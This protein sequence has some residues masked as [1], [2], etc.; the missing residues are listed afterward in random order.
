MRTK[1]LARYYAFYLDTPRSRSW[2]VYDRI[3]HRTIYSYMP[4]REAKH[5]ARHMNKMWDEE[6]R[7]FRQDLDI[8][9][10]VS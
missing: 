7:K 5:V 4:K 1:S 9:V 8:G 6:L 10:P 3:R 2:C